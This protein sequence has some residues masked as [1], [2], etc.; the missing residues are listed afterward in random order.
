MHSVQVLEDPA[1]S[2][3]P[4]DLL[5]RAMM[6]HDFLRPG[7][8]FEATSG[9]LDPSRRQQSVTIHSSEFSLETMVVDHG[10]YLEFVA[11]IFRP[12]SSKTAE[13]NFLRFTSPMM[14]R[15]GLPVQSGST[16]RLDSSYAATDAFPSSLTEL[17]RRHKLIGLIGG[18]RA[19]IE[20]IPIAERRTWH[21]SRINGFLAELVEE[22]SKHPLLRAVRTV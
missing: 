13:M 8:N 20:D 10:S 17:C 19:A 21:S 16:W 1:E 15:D 11:R 22:M 9:D 3:S 18:S 6:D 4:Y 2:V 5:L 12:V 7:G 14:S